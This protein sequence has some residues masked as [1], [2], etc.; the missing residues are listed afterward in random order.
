MQEEVQPA[1]QIL[2]AFVGYRESLRLPDQDLQAR[3]HAELS[4]A[5]ASHPHGEAI[6]KGIELTVE[7]FPKIV[8]LG[9]FVGIAIAQAIL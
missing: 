3:R 7:N 8:L 6:A 9:I 5:V 4:A 2:R 1:V